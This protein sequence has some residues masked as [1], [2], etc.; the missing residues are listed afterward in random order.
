MDFPAFVATMR[1]RRLLHLGHVDA[2]CDAL[3]SAYALS[4]ILPGDVGCAQ[5]L[6]TSARDLAEWLGLAPLIDPDPAAYDY[7]IIYDTPSLFLLGAPLPARYALFDHHVPGGHRFSNFQSRLADG[8]EWCWVRPVESTCS[9]LVDLFIQHA[10]PTSRPMSIALAAGIVTDTGWLEFANAAALRRLAAVL[11]PSK[12]FL[13]D[14]WAAIDSPN[15]RSSRRSAV[16]KALRDVRE[17]L[18]GRWSILAAHTSSHDNG[19]VVSAALGRLGADVRVVAFPKNGMA[20]VMIECDGALVEQTGV[21]MA[22][23]A[24]GVAQAAGSSHT[25]GTRPWGRV[26]APLPQGELLEQ[27]MAAIAVSLQ[28]VGAVQVQPSL[29]PHKRSGGASPKISR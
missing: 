19:F 15:R 10:V 23:V 21:N 18:V 28:K 4:C 12:L 14:V 22:A 5:G 24:A 26:I 16:L 8:A 1:G 3:G 6:K 7:T 9:I 2:D 13:E 17:T 20:M 29:P 27:C 25:W 11:E